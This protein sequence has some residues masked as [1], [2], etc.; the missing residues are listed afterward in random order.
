MVKYDLKQALSDLAAITIAAAIVLPSMVFAQSS[1]LTVQPSTGRVGVN[2]GNNS[3]AE[4][5]DVNGTVR[6]NAFKGDGS[7]LCNLPLRRQTR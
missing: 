2:I 3:P 5:L 7:K 6:A 1:P 4:T